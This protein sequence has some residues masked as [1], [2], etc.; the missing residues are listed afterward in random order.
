MFC[1]M[2]SQARRLK[3]SDSSVTVRSV[4]AAKTAVGML[5]RFV[6]NVSK[7]A[8]ARESQSVA[9]LGRRGQQRDTHPRS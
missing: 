5:S 6:S 1:D 4:R 2:A 3:R 7:P 9:A 8:L